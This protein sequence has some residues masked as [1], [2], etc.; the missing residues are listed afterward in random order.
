MPRNYSAAYRET[1]NRVSAAEA[2]LLMIEI[3]HPQLTQ[4]I[5]VVNDTQDLTS[6]GN[7][8]VA[9]AFRATLPDDK[10]KQL[11]RARLAVDNVG[12]DLV[13]WLELSGGGEGATCRMMQVLRSNP[14]LI[15]WEVTLD[16]NNVSIDWVEVGGD[17]G[18]TDILNRPG[19]VITYRPDVC[20]GL[21]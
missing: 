15:E 17:L 13:G 3:A 19:T 12:R 18:F 9:L 21:Y 7:L 8:F 6:N 1:I 10:D 4:P 14:N 11:P 16:L 5:R 2:P 20:P